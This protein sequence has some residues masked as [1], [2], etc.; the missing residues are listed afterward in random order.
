[1]HATMRDEQK[2]VQVAKEKTALWIPLSGSTLS[3][4][5]KFPVRDDREYS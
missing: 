3:I 1:M 5:G 4:P 2:V